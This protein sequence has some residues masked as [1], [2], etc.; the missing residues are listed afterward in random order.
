M[1]FSFLLHS[2]VWLTFPVFSQ[3]FSYSSNGCFSCFLGQGHHDWLVGLPRHSDN[4][5]SNGWQFIS[6]RWLF[7]RTRYRNSWAMIHHIRPNQFTRWPSNTPDLCAI[8]INKCPTGSWKVEAPPDA[9]DL[10]AGAAAALAVDRSGLSIRA[11][12][13]APGSR[14]PVC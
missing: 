13:S 7:F 5:T 3:I 9:S 4:K 1:S 11:S 6:T 12:P 2:S 10:R 14:G 8:V